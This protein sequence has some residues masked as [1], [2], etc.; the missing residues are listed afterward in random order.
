MK[1]LEPDN[2]DYF[3]KFSEELWPIGQKEE[4]LKMIKEARPQLSEEQKG[5]ILIFGTGGGMEK[6]SKDFEQLF[7]DKEQWKK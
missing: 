6:G 4:F 2:R 7:N 3:D 5:Q 1:G